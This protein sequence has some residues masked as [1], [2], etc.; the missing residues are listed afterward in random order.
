MFPPVIVLVLPSC[1]WRPPSLPPTATLYEGVVFYLYFF[2]PVL[3]RKPLLSTWKI[4]RFEEDW[5]F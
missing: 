3:L 5:A 1:P 2:I 4:E